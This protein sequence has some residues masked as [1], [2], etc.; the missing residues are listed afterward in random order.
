MWTYKPRHRE[1]VPVSPTRP[2]T[3]VEL[4]YRIVGSWPNTLRVLTLG[5]GLSFSKTLGKDALEIIRLATSEIGLNH[6]AAVPDAIWGGSSIL[7]C[8]IIAV[9]RRFTHSEASENNDDT[10]TTQD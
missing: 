9:A 2:L 8:T 5:I 7:V 10:Q 4:I 3:V 6:A 1:A